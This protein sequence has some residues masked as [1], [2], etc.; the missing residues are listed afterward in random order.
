MSSKTIYFITGANRGLGRGLLELFLSR[1]NSIVIAGVRDPSNDTS[2]SLSSITVGEGSKLVVV[3]VDSLSETDAK[4]AVE[5]LKSEHG[6]DHLDI[7]VANSGIAK[8]FGPALETPISEL[9]DHINVNTIGTLVLF[10]A[11]WPLLQFSQKP[12][13]ILISTAIASMG[14]MEQVPMAITAY[15]A[16]KAAANFIVLK[17]HNEHP[18]LTVFPLHPGWVQTD[19]GN[20]GA[21]ANGLT[22]APVVLKDSIDGMVTLVSVKDDVSSIIRL[23]TDLLS[24]SL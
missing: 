13:F 23:V 11:T 2:K 14:Y 10:Q 4:S 16:S 15:G 17:I 3:K 22:E 21:R 6:I 9:R 7:V 12:K 1:P 20:A 5:V 24:F 18:Q 19:M 8:Y